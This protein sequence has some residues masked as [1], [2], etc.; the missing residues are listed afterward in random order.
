M[1]KT[2]V[3]SYFQRF[4]ENPTEEVEILSEAAMELTGKELEGLKSR[5]QNKKD[6]E[7]KKGKSNV[8]T[9][10]PA[11]EASSSKT[12]EER[13]MAAEQKVVEAFWS[14]LEKMDP[15]SLMSLEVTDA[16]KYVGYDPDVVLRELLFRGKKAKRSQEELKKDMVDIVTIAIIKGSITEKNLQK[17]SDAGKLMY[18][19]LQETYNLVTGGAKG[20]DS[21]HLTTAR[22]AAAVPGLVTQILIK[23]P[24]FAKTFVG[25][26]GSK[27][28]PPYLRHQAAA[29]CIPEGSSEKL[30]EYLLGLITAYT[31][32]Q[33]KNLSKTKDS[34]E[35]LFDSQLNYVMTTFNGHHPT[36]EHRKKIF[37]NFSLS[38]DFEKLNMVAI[39]IKKVKTDFQT[40]TQQELDAELSK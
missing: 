9:K 10:K 29:A 15:V 39:K 14:E 3:D 37:Q 34:A 6:K 19:K 25:P 36:E 30:K 2:S 35:E 26:F 4:V 40:L 22:V 32:D 27:S 23:K 11:A 1:S 31:A 20:R 38:N 17:T 18:K 12:D 24:E 33:T 7:A 8:N 28:L 13:N 5:V 21:T 16:F